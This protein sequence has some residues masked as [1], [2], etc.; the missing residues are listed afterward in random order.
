MTVSSPS[1]HLIAVG[2]DRPSGQTPL[3]YAQS[4]AIKIALAFAGQLGAV[5]QENVTLLLGEGATWRTLDDLLEQMERKNPTFLIFFFAGHGDG[6]G[7][8]LADRLYSFALL[9]KRINRIGARGTVLM[10]DCCGAGGFS[11]SAALEGVSVSGIEAAWWPSLFAAVPG[12]RV[13]MASDWN[14]Y[15]SEVEGVGGVYTDSIIRAMQLPAPGDILVS[16]GSFVSDALVFERAKKYMIERGLQPTRAGKFGR[17]PLAIANDR[18]RGSA[19]VSS[20]GA[21]DGGGVEVS[22]SLLSRLLLPTRISLTASDTAGSWSTESVEV[23]PQSSW[24]E[25]SAQFFI[26]LGSSQRTSR[27]I[28]LLGRCTIQWLVQVSD[29]EGRVLLSERYSARYAA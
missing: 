26:D 3:S 29:A 5:P 28:L 27:R 13:F 17:L 11:K 2:V 9:R 16:T 10:L 14:K 4:D 7:I 12:V 15:T 21:L 23:V 22:V 19:T 25:E 8:S 6:S 1:I 20:I 24:C 18:P